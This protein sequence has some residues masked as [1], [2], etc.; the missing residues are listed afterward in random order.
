MQRDFR[1]LLSMFAAAL[2]TAMA[3]HPT[4]VVANQAPDPRSYQVLVSGEVRYPGRATLTAST[5]T[6]ADALSAVGS[7][8]ENAGDDVVVIRPMRPGGLPERAVIALKDI[9]LG[10]LGVDVTLRDGDIVNVPLAQHYF[11]SGFVVSP[12]A[13]K[14]RAGTTVAQAILL[15]GGLAEGGTERRP[16]I[17]RVV[18]GKTVEVVGK[19][20]DVILP[21]DLIKVQR[22]MF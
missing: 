18:K 8:T 21:N 5:M 19:P 14:L 7:P 10:T 2:L 13:Y 4:R 17:V 20:D 15:V 22:R 6:V 11:I 1:G 16:R 9:D 12:G 3:T